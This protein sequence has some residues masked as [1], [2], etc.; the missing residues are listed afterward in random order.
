MSAVPVARPWRRF[1]RFSVRGLIVLVLVIGVVLGWI[2]RSA[3]IQRNAVA[4]ITKAGGYVKYDWEWQSLSPIPNGKPMY[5]RWLVDRL[6]VDYFGNVSYVHFDHNPQT[7][8][9]ELADLKGLNRLEQLYLCDTNITDAGLAHVSGLTP[10][11]FLN[12]RRTK[13]GDLGLGHLERLTRLR[14][15]LLGGTRVTDVG[16]VHLKELTSLEVLDLDLTHITDAGL[17]HLKGLTKLR[18][19]NLI[20][21]DVTDAGVKELQQA[22]PGLKITR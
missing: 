9:A 8:D 17:V 18:E 3:H 11:Q 21:T 4:A 10:L 7:G 6:G 5:P 22:L 1:L 20:H 15:L 19:L 16:L 2:V 13:L 14:S 12:L